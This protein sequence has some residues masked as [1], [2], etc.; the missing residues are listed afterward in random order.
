MKIDGKVKGQNILYRADCKEAIQRL[1]D[2]EV[3]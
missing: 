3:L 1:I 2:K